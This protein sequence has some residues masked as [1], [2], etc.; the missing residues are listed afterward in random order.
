MNF[1]VVL[2]Q[3]RQAIADMLNVLPRIINGLV[4]LLVGYLLAAAVR[5]VLRFVLR[6]LGFDTLMERLGIADWV[7]RIGLPHRVSWLVAQVVFVLLLLSFAATAIRLMGLVAVATL[8]DRL[9]TYLPNTIAAL[10]VF[11]LGGVGAT[12]A[13][14]L[15]TTSAAGSGLGYAR[16]LGQ[17]VQYLLTVF[18]IVLAL[19][20][21]GVNTSILVTVL[22][23]LI[24]A[25][26]LALGLALGLGARH[27]VVNILAGHYVRE[28]FAIGQPLVHEGMRGAISQIG[29]V[30]TIMTTDEGSLLIPHSLLLVTA[31]RAGRRPEGTPPPEAPDAAST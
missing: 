18:V 4:L 2:D 11:L 24:A 8:L 14:R 5:A 22:P 15:V 9:L 12:Y 25:F 10:I 17:I 20:A 19:D 7:R 27:V 1:Q 6:R 3:L 13:G 28:H 31:V 16:L 26:G 29:S 21:L 23:L 30:Y